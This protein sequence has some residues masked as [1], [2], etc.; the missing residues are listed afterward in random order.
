MYNNKILFMWGSG[1]LDKYSLLFL[2]KKIIS[3][4]NILIIFK[5]YVLE[6]FIYIKIKIY[7]NI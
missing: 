1:T 4:G 6:I 5:T 2:F 3:M 7:I